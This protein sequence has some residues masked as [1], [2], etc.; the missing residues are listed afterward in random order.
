M[1]PDTWQLRKWLCEVPVGLP[2]GEKHTSCR[3]EEHVLDCAI[4]VCVYGYTLACA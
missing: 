2:R 3:R 1:C 4:P